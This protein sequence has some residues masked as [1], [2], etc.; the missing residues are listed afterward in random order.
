MIVF[1]DLPV[2]RR[3]IGKIFVEPKVFRAANAENNSQFRGK[4][5]QSYF[6]VDESYYRSFWYEPQVSG[7]LSS[8]LP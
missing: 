8:N 7:A 6:D 3:R 2:T 4:D 1:H 5:L